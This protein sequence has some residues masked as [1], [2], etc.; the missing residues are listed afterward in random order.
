MYTYA[1]PFLGVPL[2]QMK[3][4]GDITLLGEIVQECDISL[5]ELRQNCALYQNDLTTQAYAL[6]CFIDSIYDDLV[7]LNQKYGIDINFYSDYHGSDER[8]VIFGA[9]ID[10][11]LNI[12][13][14]GCRRVDMTSLTTMT[15][16]LQELQALFAE[17]KDS[18]PIDLYIN[19]HSS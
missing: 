2:S 9:Y 1:R 6:L 11:W 14:M 17:H 19:N 3:I 5:S 8:P 12:P 13:D 4:N 15:S 7:R 18:F 10:S 16:C